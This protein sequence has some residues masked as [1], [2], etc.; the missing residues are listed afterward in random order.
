MGWGRLKFKSGDLRISNIIKTL[1]NWVDIHPTVLKPT[2]CKNKRSDKNWFAEF[3]EAKNTAIFYEVKED[4]INIK[5][6]TRRPIFSSIIIL[7][8]IHNMWKN[9]IKIN[10]S[11]Y[12]ILFHRQTHKVAWINTHTHIHNILF[13]WDVK[14]C[15]AS[16]IFLLFP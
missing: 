2:W 6:H 4:G 14:C 11:I 15:P 16:T 3:N 7:T 9:F 5:V 12:E 13:A 8:D 1:C 10:S